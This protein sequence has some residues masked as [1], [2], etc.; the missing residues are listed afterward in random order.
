[1]GSRGDRQQT[2]PICPG[3]FVPHCEGC[4]VTLGPQEGQARASFPAALLQGMPL[5]LELRQSSAQLPLA[6]FLCSQDKAGRPQASPSAHSYLAHPVLP[7]TPFSHHH[8]RCLP[9]PRTIS[10]ADMS[11]PQECQP[12]SE[13]ASLRKQRIPGFMQSLTHTW[14]GPLGA[15]RA[16]ENGDPE[17]H[18]HSHNHTSLQ[19]QPTL[20]LTPSHWPAKAKSTADRTSLY[21]LTE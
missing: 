1:M 9:L 19:T 18:M 16:C 10:W 17:T 13:T 11:E 4:S 7:H 6:A 5:A 12:G 3:S 2:G 8:S 15:R 20:T 21:S 14:S